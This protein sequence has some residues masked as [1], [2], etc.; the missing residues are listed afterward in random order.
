MGSTTEAESPEGLRAALTRAMSAEPAVILGYL[1]GSHASGRS[2]EE[3]DVDLAVLLQAQAA[4]GWAVAERLGHVCR[5]AL[6]TARVDVLTLNRAPPELAFAVVARGERLYET[7][8]AARVEFEAATLA[9]HGDYVPFLRAQRREILAGRDDGTRV[10]RYR[11]S[12]GRTL[13][14]LGEIARAGGKAPG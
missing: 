9:R 2:V 3:S 5:R 12:L 1:F 11:T 4:E 14:T 10:Q 8:R 13:R 6:G 7:N